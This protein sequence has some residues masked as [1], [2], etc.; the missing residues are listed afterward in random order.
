MFQTAKN[1]GASVV[2]VSEQGRNQ[3]EDN[4]WFNDLSDKAA[5]YVTK[6]TMIEVVVPP[7]NGFHWLQIGDI[8]IY[9]VYWSTNVLLSTFE[10]FL[11][12]LKMSV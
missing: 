5:L 2:L 8:R 10:D 12:R 7:E 9:S 1:V 11:L 3:G 4:G 6:M